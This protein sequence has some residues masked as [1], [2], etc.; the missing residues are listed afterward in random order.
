[1]NQYREHLFN[2]LSQTPAGS[3]V[4]SRTRFLRTLIESVRPAKATQF[5]LAE[6]RLEI[7]AELLETHGELRLKF[8]Q[9][10]YGILKSADF[11]SLFVKSGI[12]EKSGFSTELMRRLKHKFLPPEEPKDSLSYCIDSIFYRHDDYRWVGRIGEE[13][14]LHLFKQ[15]DMGEVPMGGNLQHQ[16]LNSLLL[17]SYRITGFGME[18]EIL[19]KLPKD[20]ALRYSFLDQ[21]KMIVQLV[22]DLR[23]GKYNQQEFNLAIEALENCDRELKVLKSHISEYGTSL[24]Q[25]FIVRQLT[26]LI[27]RARLLLD[28][29]DRGHAL[30]MARFSHTF[31]QFV[32]FQNTRNDL[33][34][35]ISGNIAHLSYRI[36]EH[37]SDTGEHYIAHTRAEF[38]TFFHSS[39]IA[40][41]VVSFLVIFKSLLHHAHLA[42]FW[43]SMAYSLNYAIGFVA[44][45][46]LGGT[47]ATKQPAMTASW[48]AGSMDNKRSEKASLH[49]LAVMV[50]KILRSQNISFIGN[51]L[52]VF[53]LATLWSWLFDLATGHP[54]AEGK[55]AQH[56]LDDVNPLTSLA[57]PY[58]ALTGFFLFASGLFS[59]Y[60]ENRVVYSQLYRRLRS[61]KRLRQLLGPKKLERWASFLEHKLGAISGNILLGFLLGFSTFI[62]LIFA[63]PFD[64]RH[65]TFSTGNMAIGLYGTG[66]SAGTGELILLILGI[67]GIGLFNFLFSF[68]L[69]F[70]VAVRS[71]NVDFSQYA[72]FN[73]IL[74][75]YFCRYPGDFIYPPSRERSGH[76][77]EKAISPVSVSTPEIAKEEVVEK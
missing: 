6:T 62:G 71:R 20:D 72:R 63:L 75:R 28:F 70:Y 17:L 65:I 58:A 3:S 67:A 35:F 44:I 12:P 48:I 64:I 53:P 2:L 59:G 38:R 74:F 56:L 46:L 43:E 29:L 16:L 49:E 23:E 13:V 36:A 37:E 1:M 41:I 47:L 39:C 9:A 40:G 19:G 31:K 45:Y 30:N 66:Y 8:N 27:R 50:A 33:G 69:A 76:E 11:T 68:G 21:N 10:L 5:K 26:L 7:L 73:K 24:Y 52:L 22:E 25:N 55:A 34:K 42:P 77:L 54:L 14:W 32:Y 4:L 57:L 61:H 51:L 60:I 15:V 18:S